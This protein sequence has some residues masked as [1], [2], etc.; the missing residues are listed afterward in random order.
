MNQEKFDSFCD[1]IASG[2]S[3]KKAC[4]QLHI[5]RD[6]IWAHL[7]DDKDAG[8]KYARAVTNRTESMVDDMIDIA[9]DK[10]INPRDKHEMIDARKWL[11]SKM[12]PKKY[13]SALDGNG[14][15]IRITITGKGGKE[16]DI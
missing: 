6:K 1:L 16:L 4:E 15:P 10:R 9:D 7:R 13:G 12:L 14:E 8:D 5:S 2:L 3:G 11:A